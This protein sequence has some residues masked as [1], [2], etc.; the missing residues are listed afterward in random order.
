MITL[1]V[2][3]GILSFVFVLVFSS[4]YEGY[5][6][7]MLWRWF[8]VPTFGV[9]QLPIV[10]AIG[11]VLMMGYLTHQIYDFKKEEKEEENLTVQTVKRITVTIL[12]PTLALV[13][14]WIVHLFM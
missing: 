12:K 13:F 5:V 10:P 4:I 14:G 3:F 2:F 11:I 7:S 1:A 6:L 9:S 8:V